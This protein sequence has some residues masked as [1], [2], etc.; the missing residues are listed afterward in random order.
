MTRQAEPIP[1]LGQGPQRFVAEALA[2][3]RIETRFARMVSEV[4]SDGLVLD[5]G[6]ELDVGAV[7]LATGIEASSLTRFIPGEHDAH[8]RLLVGPDLWV[9][10]ID[11]VFAEAD[12]AHAFADHVTYMSCRHAIQLGRYAGHKIRFAIFLACPQSGIV[13]NGYPP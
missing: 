10:G 7:I 6:E 3:C 12:T 5:S 8:G 13:K 4:H 2:E 9:D 1:A 11:I